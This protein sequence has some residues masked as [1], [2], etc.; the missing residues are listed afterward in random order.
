[1]GAQSATWQRTARITIAGED[2]H[3]PSRGALALD[4]RASSQHSSEVPRGNDAPRIAS[5]PPS[6]EDLKRDARQYRR[7]CREI[8]RLLDQGRL[9]EARALNEEARILSQRL[10]H[11]NSRRDASIP[12]PASDTGIEWSRFCGHCGATSAIE[13]PVPVAR[14]CGACGLGMLLEARSDVAPGVDDAFLVV[15]SSLSVQAISRRAERALSVR[16]QR[17][18]SRHVTELLVPAGVED[19]RTHGLAVAIT[20][21]AGGEQAPARVFVRPASTFGV[22]LQA[23]IA[24]CGPA[25]AALLVFE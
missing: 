14:V 10:Y 9:S 11:R 16:E 21:A 5:A 25:P 8:N 17:A 12:A 2:R 20:R 13:T 15:D 1:L 19:Q 18:V 23:R 3:R 4:V 22:R 24:A 6:N 7:L